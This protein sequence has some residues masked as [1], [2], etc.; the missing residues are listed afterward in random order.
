MKIV[1]IIQA[2]C[3]STRFP[4]K[5]FANI[6]DLPLIWHVVNRL[7]FANTLT[8]IVLATT[9]NPLD[10]EL[11]EWAALNHIKTF[12]G[13]ENNVLNRYYEAAKFV[14]ADVIVR[15]TADDPFKEPC[16]IDQAVC[17]LLKTQIDFVSNNYPPSYP[18]GL[19]V[20]VFTKSALNK[21]EKYATSLFEQE[22]V[23]QY[24]YHNLSMFSFFNISHSSDLSFYRWTIDTKEDLMMVQRVYSL[25]Y[26][27]SKSIFHMED[28]L[29]L[30]KQYPEISKM[31]MNVA[32]SE[33][34]KS[35]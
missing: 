25:L 20:E 18:E 23:T 2:R 13:S 17:K 30:L 11:C 33:M 3:G 21:A 4:N 9:T 14:D 27:D 34:Y 29:S 31:N 22:H 10:D 6:C 26:K 35:K 16:I 1:A 28:I 8:E 12:R 7:K 5:V 32:R 15:I 24:F 19:D